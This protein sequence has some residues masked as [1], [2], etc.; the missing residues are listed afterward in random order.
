MILSVHNFYAF[1]NESFTLIIFSLLHLRLKKL[2]SQIFS[3]AILYPFL[4][5]ALPVITLHF[6]TWHGEEWD[7]IGFYFLLFWVT[8]PS[9]S[10]LLWV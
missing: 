8:L 7:L 3:I 9:W 2:L 5:V 1:I 4:H 10:E 6:T